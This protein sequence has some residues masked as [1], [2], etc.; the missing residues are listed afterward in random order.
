MEYILITIL[1]LFSIAGALFLDVRTRRDKN[2]FNRFI[3]KISGHKPYNFANE[4]KTSSTHT[5]SAMCE[6]CSSKLFGSFVTGKY[7]KKD[8]WV[9]II[10]EK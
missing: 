10:L 2:A 7:S 4:F 5:K 6:R 8:F 9:W 1:F 3:C